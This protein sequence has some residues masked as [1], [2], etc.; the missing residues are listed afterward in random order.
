MLS[1][2][3]PIDMNVNIP[4]II[5]YAQKL[6]DL[7]SNHIIAISESHIMMCILRNA[8]NNNQVQVATAERPPQK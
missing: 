5:A 1:M 4:E 2:D 8:D 3:T 7:L 6:S